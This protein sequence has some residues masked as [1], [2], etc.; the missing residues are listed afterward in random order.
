MAD[1]SMAELMKLLEAD[2]IYIPKSVAHCNDVYDETK[3]LFGVAFTDCVD[4]LM[5]YGGCIDG[6][7]VG[8]MMKAYIMDMSIADIQYECLCSSSMA[9][10]ARSETVSLINRVNL[11]E[12]LR[13]RQVI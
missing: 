12:C 11:I 6:Q 1:N 5:A 10:A 3:T 7:T 8:R 9:S 4:N 2:T 13:E